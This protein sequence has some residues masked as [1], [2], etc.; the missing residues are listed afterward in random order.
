M[1][2]YN[3]LVLVILIFRLL[4]AQ[5]QEQRDIEIVVHRGANHLAPENTY[6]AARKC[7]EM[8]LD[9]V[10]IDVRRSQ[11]GVHY[12]LHDYNLN[13]TT[14]GKGAIHKTKSEE[15]DQL[16]AGSWFAEEFTG[17]KVPRLTEYLKWIKGKAKVYLDVKDADLAHVIQ[18]IKELKMEKETFFWFGRDQM[19]REFRQLAPD[20]NLKINASDKDKVMKVKEEYNP[21]IIE[22]NLQAM[23]DQDFVKTCKDLGLKIMIYASKNTEEE[24]AGVIQSKADMVNLDKPL[25]YLQVLKKLN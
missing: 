18:L 24:F 7:I 9:Y 10:E 14:N 4:P 25:L 11:D 1:N 2:R 20:L 21:Q 6:A 8:G 13:R 23:Q 3:Y 15:I 5:A 19:A 22:C 12:I 17:E 16:D